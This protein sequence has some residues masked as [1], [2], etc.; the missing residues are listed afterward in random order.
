[1]VLVLV[2]VVVGAGCGGVWALVVLVVLCCAVLCC[3]GGNAV[4]RV[5]PVH[6]GLKNERLFAKGA[7]RYRTPPRE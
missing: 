4:R 5:K 6:P 2:L 1:V 7:D 3:A